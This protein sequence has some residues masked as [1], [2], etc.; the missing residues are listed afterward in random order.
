MWSLWTRREGH[1]CIG[2][3]LHQTGLSRV[4]P[5]PEATAWTYWTRGQKHSFSRCGPVVQEEV[6]ST[7]ICASVINIKAA[8]FQIRICRLNAD[9]TFKKMCN[10]LFLQD[11]TDILNNIPTTWIRNLDRQAHTLVNTHTFG[12]SSKQ[13]ALDLMAERY[14]SIWYSSS[15]GNTQVLEQITC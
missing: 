4:K 12:P 10:I 2:L 15:E 13:W 1:G 11:P 5:C 6:G 8:L 3:V 7:N 9:A 14:A